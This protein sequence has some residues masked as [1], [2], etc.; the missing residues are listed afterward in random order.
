MDH[1]LFRLLWIW[2]LVGVAFAVQCFACTLPEISHEQD[3]QAPSNAVDKPVSKKVK[4]PIALSRF[5]QRFNPHVGHEQAQQIALAIFEEAQLRG[6]DP[7]LVAALFAR[8][9]SFNQ[10]AVSR[11]N[12]KGLGQLKDFHYEKYQVSNPFDVA[13]NVRASV[14]LLADLKSAWRGEL[15]WENNFNRE[16]LMLSSYFIGLGATKRSN[17]EL[18]EK[19][20]KYI[21]EIL[22]YRNQVLSLNS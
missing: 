13:Q 19:A 12:A 20:V 7:Y 1:K 11:T 8:E 10:Y 3:E 5:I 14:A 2:V 15:S 17:G 16:E 21:R 6:M 18:P 9:S 22:D 4:N